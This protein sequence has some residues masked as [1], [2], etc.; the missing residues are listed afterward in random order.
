MK[1]IIIGAGGR[2]RAALVREYRKKFD[3]ISF[4]GAQRNGGCRSCEC[5]LKRLGKP[6][7]LISFVTDRLG[8]DPPLRH[9]FVT[10]SAR[11]VVAT[12]AWTGGPLLNYN[13]D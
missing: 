8:H 11:I 13:L 7:R 9:R 10:R 3:M 4:H 5:V 2:L 6:E 12:I 1:I